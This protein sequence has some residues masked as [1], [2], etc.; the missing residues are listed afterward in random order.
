M[1]ERLRGRLLLESA[2]FESNS[3]KTLDP[4]DQQDLFSTQHRPLS[5][6]AWR[7]VLII[8][9]RLARSELSE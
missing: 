8:V 5:A 7:H 1:S 4:R 6:L 9:T 2:A 3:N